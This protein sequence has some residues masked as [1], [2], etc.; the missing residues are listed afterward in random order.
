[1]VRFIRLFAV[2]LMYISFLSAGGQRVLS[3]KPRAIDPQK[4]TSPGKIWL[5]GNLLFVNDKTLGVHIFNITIPNLPVRLCALDVPENTDIAVLSNALY[6][7]SK[8]NMLV[9]DI[10]DPV[11]PKQVATV[12]NLFYYEEPPGPEY[13]EGEA[14]SGFWGCTATGCGDDGTGNG[15]GIPGSMA[16]FAVVDNF[17]YAADRS[18]LRVF[19]VSNPT[20]PDSYGRFDAPW[21]IETARWWRDPR[22]D[23]DY[24]FMGGMQGIFLYSVT[25]KQLPVQLA[26]LTNINYVQPVVASGLFAY[27][28]ARN[29]YS[30]GDLPSSR[31][32]V[33]SLHQLTNIQVLVTIGLDSPYGL[34][35]ASNT[36]YVCDGYDGIDI[37]DVS[38]PSNTVKTNR[39]QGID[40]YDVIACSN[41]LIVTG[42]SGVRLYSITNM[43][44]P[45]FQ[46]Q[47]Q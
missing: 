32:Q 39:I 13:Y 18:T 34:A 42:N 29:D 37:F 31:L 26:R 7:N 5:Q 22:D 35:V 11:H 46:A 19:D 27:T 44:E 23:K 8:A 10:T 25:N 21:S 40:G 24:L 6:V 3:D 2:M 36:L 47:L 17:L 16:R 1:M 9:Y 12:S 43:T 28:T 45:A 41:S 14:D 30:G 4:I 15:A 33:L 38:N 20:N